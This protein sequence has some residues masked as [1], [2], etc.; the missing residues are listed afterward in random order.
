[1]SE[2]VVAGGVGGVLLG[3]VLRRADLCFHSMFRGL[4]AGRRQLAAIWAVGVSVAAVGLSVVYQVSAWDQLNRG[5]AFHPVR[6]VLGGLLFG[7]GMVVALSCVSGLFYKLGAGM[8]GAVVGLGGWFLGEV[9]VRDHV[10]ELPGE[11]VLDPGD[12]GTLPEVIGRIPGVPDLPRVV[13]AAVLLG[14]VVVALRRYPPGRPKGAWRWPVA[15]VALGVATTVAWA[16]AGWSGAG[17]GPSTVGTPSAIADGLAGDGWGNEWQLAFLAG[18]VVGSAGWSAAS[19][20]LWVRWEDLPRLAGLAAGGAL[21][22][23]GA[24]IAGGCN[25]GH[26]LSGVAQ[27]GI[28]SY[29]AVASMIAGVWLTAAAVGSLQRAISSGR[30]AR[31]GWRITTEVPSEKTGF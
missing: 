26:G 31:T 3:L 29:V 6:N 1:M 22:G 12:G 24:V 28:G 30:K 25:L 10:S 17:F 20:K 23:A 14:L 19:G 9:A 8:L 15:G 7:A 4:L 27:M 13:V 11:R 16:L 2:L 5:L 18:I 21:L